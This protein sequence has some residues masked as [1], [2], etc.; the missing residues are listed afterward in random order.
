MEMARR[1]HYR[2]QDGY[3]EKVYRFDPDVSA[4]V[5]IRAVT[6][7]APSTYSERIIRVRRTQQCLYGE[8]NGP[9][10]KSRGPL[11]FEDV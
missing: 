9:D 4:T 10:L 7:L 8:Q 2:I 5:L 6:S 1:S 3:E 11:V